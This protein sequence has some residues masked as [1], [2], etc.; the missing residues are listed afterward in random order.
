MRK[1]FSIGPKQKVLRSFT[2]SS[3]Q[4]FLLPNS[5]SKSWISNNQI[6]APPAYIYTH[7]IWAKGVTGFTHLDSPQLLFLF[8]SLYILLGF[9]CDAKSHFRAANV[10]TPRLLCIIITIEASKCGYSQRYLSADL[11]FRGLIFHRTEDFFVNCHYI[12][13]KLCWPFR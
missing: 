8:R 5:V 6:A 1:L 2:R 3:L 12:Y 11:P 13:N 10:N 4:V 7:S 9:C